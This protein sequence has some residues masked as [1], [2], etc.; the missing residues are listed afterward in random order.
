[1]SN[2]LTSLLESILD[3]GKLED[4]Y[5]KQKEKYPKILN[6]IN[7]LEKNKIATNYAAWIIK[8]INV[9]SPEPVKDILPLISSFEKNK[10]KLDKKDIR[11]S[12]VSQTRAQ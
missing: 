1:M 10:W 12:Q 5:L 4:F 11:C 3:E 7:Y 8:Q 2:N 9:P 6:Q